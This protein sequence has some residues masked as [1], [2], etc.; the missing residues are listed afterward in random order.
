[1]CVSMY[2]ILCKILG[3]NTPQGGPQL[4]N[5]FCLGAEYVWVMNM[6]FKN[7]LN[8][9]YSACSYL[10]V[11]HFTFEDFLIFINTAPSSSYWSCELCFDK[12]PSLFTFSRLCV[13]C[14]VGIYRKIIPLL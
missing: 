14:K 2:I 3:P 4:L 1:M 9:Y 5:H 6:F 12:P 10:L 13:A 8:D 11:P 7:M